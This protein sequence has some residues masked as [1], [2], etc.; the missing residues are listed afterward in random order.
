[1]DVLNGKVSYGNSVRVKFRSIHW[2]GSMNI[3]LDKDYDDTWYITLP[4]LRP[5]ADESV[6]TSDYDNTNPMQ[7]TSLR[8]KE[9][10]CLKWIDGEGDNCLALATTFHYALT[11]R[12][13]NFVEGKFVTINGVELIKTS[14]IRTFLAVYMTSL[15]ASLVIAMDAIGHDI[16]S[17]KGLRSF[18]N[19]SEI[20]GTFDASISLGDQVC[21]VYQRETVFKSHAVVFHQCKFI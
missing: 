8:E 1:M 5:S 20:D 3:C 6:L 10:L 18:L 9:L 12:D 13:D 15:R 21:K 7:V 17:Y 16:Y 19:V 14:T 4:C 2:S 11:F